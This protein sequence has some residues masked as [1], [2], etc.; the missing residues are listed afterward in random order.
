[1]SAMLVQRRKNRRVSAC[2]LMANE[3]DG[4]KGRYKEP[5]PELRFQNFVESLMAKAIA[6]AKSKE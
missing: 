6:V 5:A 1:M 2:F 3:R 4:L